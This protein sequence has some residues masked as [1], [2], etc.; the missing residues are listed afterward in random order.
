MK[1][2]IR[3]GIE[4]SFNNAIRKNVIFNINNNVWDKT[5]RYFWNNDSW[6]LLNVIRHKVSIKIEQRN[7]EIKP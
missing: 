1:K 3:V 7:G 2:E 5:S 4:K 6:S